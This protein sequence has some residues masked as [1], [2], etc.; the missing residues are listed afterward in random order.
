MIKNR[1]KKG[2]SPLVATVLLI[3]FTIALGV[4]IWAWLSGFAEE[5]AG[6]VGEIAEAELTCGTSSSFKVEQACVAG[7]NIKLTIENKANN[8]LK[9]FVMRIQAENEDNADVVEVDQK[10]GALEVGIIDIQ[11][12]TVEGP[13]TVIIVPKIGVG[14][15]VTI[16]QE[17]AKEIFLQPC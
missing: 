12:D 4:V 2:I 16:C 6:K 3:G 9:G 14:N 10:I 17:E 8:E 15:K 13:E 1:G 5:R 7:K 11:T